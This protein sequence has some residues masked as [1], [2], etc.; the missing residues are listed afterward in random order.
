MAVF[1]LGSGEVGQPVRWEMVELLEVG[2][3]GGAGQVEVVDAE[4]ERIMNGSHGW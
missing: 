1:G 4:S 2:A 3:V